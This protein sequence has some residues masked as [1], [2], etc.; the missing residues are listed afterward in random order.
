MVYGGEWW[1][2]LALRDVVKHYLCCERAKQVTGVDIRG[3]PN[4]GETD[5]TFSVLGKCLDVMKWDIA[6]IDLLVFIGHW[7]RD[8]RILCAAQRLLYRTGCDVGPVCSA[9][10]IK[11]SSSGWGS[12]SLI[13]R[14]D[15]MKPEVADRKQDYSRFGSMLRIGEYL[16]PF[17]PDGGRILKQRAIEILRQH[18]ASIDDRVVQ[19]LMRDDASDVFDAIERQDEDALR[20]HCEDSLQREA[21]RKFVCE[22]T[23]ARMTKDADYLPVPLPTGAFSQVRE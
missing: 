14:I 19:L 1:G 16:R 15:Q 5:V 3:R 13:V 2:E 20:F 7:K 8:A 18:E 6:V 21:V 9:D 10:D 17:W 11:T 4:L 22:G 23:H 12:E